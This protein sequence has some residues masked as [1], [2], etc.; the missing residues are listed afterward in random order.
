LTK[1]T[2]LVLVAFIGVATALVLTLRPLR[3]RGPVGL[4][5]G[6]RQPN[7]VIVMTDDQDVN[8]MSVMNKTRELWG[9]PGV[10][11]TNAFSSDPLCCPSRA[12][13]LTGQL[14][15]NHGVWEN[16]PPGGYTALDYETTL[17]VWLRDAG[18]HTAFAGK[19]LNG[20]GTLDTRWDLTKP[21]REIPAGWDEWL[22]ILSPAE[23]NDYAV[24]VDGRVVTYGQG[25]TTRKC[26][27]PDAKQPNLYFTDL[28]AERAEAFVRSRAGK[29]EPWLL[30]VA[31][32]APH[33]VLGGTNAPPPAPRHLGRLDAAPM[34]MSE[35]YDEADVSDKPLFIRNLPP[36][37]AQWKDSRPIVYRRRLET[38]LAVDE[39]VER[40]ESA[41]VATGQA[42]DTV[43]IYT[44]DNGWANGD[45]R[46]L[47]GKFVVYE[48]SVLVPLLVRGP[49]FKA[50]LNRTELVA[51]VDLAPTLVA[52]AGA[53][54]TRIMDG[55][56][57]GPLL[58]GEDVKWRGVMPLEARHERSSFDAVR[59]ATH[60]Y[61]LHTT[62]EEELYDLG[63]DPAQL[64]SLHADP[65]H[66]AVKAELAEKLR[67]LHGCVGAGCWQ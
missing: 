2:T 57:L 39:A 11:F 25:T 21:C 56:D 66:A 7:I 49:G 61:A 53:V 44:S 60:V 42:D 55:R 5:A 63:A 41:L 4:A 31:P 34:P 13:I 52:L 20:Y 43:R 46:W 58:R 24:N 16:S 37:T 9:E 47:A 51:N 62:G 35:S 48:P 23:Y 19:F 10:T 29:A 32:Y 36:L 15:R 1:R 22:G 12:T 17:P 14:A 67:S 26:G 6:A 33:E 65:R 45:H 40:I 64:T 3:R 38:L 54:P 59:T 27:P 50:G 30:V 8:S 28:L 18:Y